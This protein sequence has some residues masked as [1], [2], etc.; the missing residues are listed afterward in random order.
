MVEVDGGRKW[1]GTVHLGLAIKYVYMFIS[2][3]PLGST[4]VA[5]LWG[6]GALVAVA[7]Q[8]EE[9]CASCAAKPDTALLAAASL[10]A[11][12]AAPLAYLGFRRFRAGRQGL[13]AGCFLGSA[14]ALGICGNQLLQQVGLRSDGGARTK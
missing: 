12:G 7:G 11:A 13:A 3:V 9:A 14:A 8:N 4:C 10:G 6:S 5:G 1:A 2:D